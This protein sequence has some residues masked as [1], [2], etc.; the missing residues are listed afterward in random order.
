MRVE[1]EEVCTSLVLR[2]RYKIDNDNLVLSGLLP[3]LDRMR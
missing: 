3:F 2:A 1:P